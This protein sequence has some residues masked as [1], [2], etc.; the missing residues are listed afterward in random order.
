MPP[1][2]AGAAA[3][4]AG[5]PARPG[6][7]TSGLVVFYLT[8]M[9]GAG[10]LVIPA[11]TARTAG[12]ASLLV[13]VGLLAASYPLA[14]LFAE[15]SARYPDA[16]GIAAFARHRLGDR[17]GDSASLLLVVLYAIGNPF[18]GLAAGRYLAHLVGLPAGTVP[19]LAIGFMLLA[20]AFNLLGL[21]TG[22]K[23]QAAALVLL[24]AGLAVAIALATPHLAVG[25]L[26]PF[27]PAGWTALGPATVIALFSFLGWENVSTIA[28]EVRDPQRTYRRAIRYA[29]PLVGA[30]YLA[31]A[32][33]FL[34]VDHPAGDPV[35]LSALLRAPFGAA[36]A[37]AGDVLGLGIIMAAANAWVL[38]ASRLVVS[39]ARR[40]L[41]PAALAGTTRRAGVPV[42]ALRALAVCYA[43]VLSAVGV[44]G[45]DEGT[46][47]AV[48]SAGFLVL[49]VVV[50]V[51]ALRTPAAAGL[52][53]LGRLT[54]LI[55]VGFLAVAGRPLAAAAV[56]AAGCLALTGLLNRRPATRA[57]IRAAS[58]PVTRPAV[59][60]AAPGHH[61]PSVPIPVGSHP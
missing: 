18:L 33:A 48:V 23:V 49:Y 21:A 38:G 47:A 53:P 34:L 24:L 2:P 30:L 3:P 56:L 19:Y 59:G 41:L 28:E 52:R 35:V 12:P 22:A 46:V 29:V 50:A 8:S 7:G 32:V 4:A 55:A 57:A 27:A 25:R 15:M 39:A 17:I 61:P 16:A 37:A 11:L 10:I 5:G 13:W 36:G 6:L 60:P 45:V 9:V 43:A 14:R 42:P 54:L 40:R 58:R 1:E 51:C 20:V 31:V 44:L 26:T